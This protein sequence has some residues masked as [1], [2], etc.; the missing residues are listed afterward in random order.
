MRKKIAACTL[1]AIMGMLVFSEYLP[2]NTTNA[3]WAEY[4]K[5]TIGVSSIHKSY[6]RSY[7]V[8]KNANISESYGEGIN[9]NQ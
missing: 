7:A 9:M 1:V 8:D 2:E 6:S 3:K 5:K 4:V